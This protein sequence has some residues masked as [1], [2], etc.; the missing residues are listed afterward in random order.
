MVFEDDS[1]LIGLLTRYSD[2][3]EINELKQA[4]VDYIST[5]TQDINEQLIQYHK[6]NPNDVPLE[7]SQADPYGDVSESNP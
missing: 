2:P 7:P 1:K 4:I 3:S 5:Q 6:E